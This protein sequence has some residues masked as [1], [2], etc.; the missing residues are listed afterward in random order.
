A[1]IESQKI[2]IVAFQ[3]DQ[4]VGYVEHDVC[5]D[6]R[7]CDQRFCSNGL[8]QVEVPGGNLAIPSICENSKILVRFNRTAHHKAAILEDWQFFDAAQIEFTSPAILHRSDRI[9]YEKGGSCRRE[10]KGGAVILTS[11][12]PNQWTGMYGPLDTKSRDQQKHR[13]KKPGASNHELSLLSNTFALHLSSAS[14]GE[15]ER[16]AYDIAISPL[17][18]VEIFYKPPSRGRFNKTKAVLVPRCLTD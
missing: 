18:F 17:F 3:L 9:R 14:R 16:D 8:T 2:G 10:L 15:R 4:E 5:H 12:G 7:I 13:G 6:T 11:P 1:Q